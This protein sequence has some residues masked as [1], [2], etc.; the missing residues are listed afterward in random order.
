MTSGARLARRYNRVIARAW[1]DPAYLGRLQTEPVAVLRESGFPV[2]D[3]V[4]VRVVPERPGE[5]SDR[6]WYLVLP[7]V[8]DTLAD[9]WL[10]ASPTKPRVSMDIHPEPGRPP[11]EPPQKPPADPQPP[12]YPPTQPQPQPPQPQPPQPPPTEPRRQQP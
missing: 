10:S 7:P 5:D 9:E 12:P 2:P 4:D 6:V 3:G 1:T 11:E 8:D